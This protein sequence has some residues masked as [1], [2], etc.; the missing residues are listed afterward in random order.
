[1]ELDERA[2]QQL[3]QSGALA[4][5]GEL[6]AGVVHEINNPLFAIL[7]LT[8]FLLKES[9]PGSRAH[10]RLE[11]IQ[12]TG[13]EIKEMVRA[14]LDFARESAD[15]GR[16]EVALADVVRST[17]ELLRRTNA[18][19][20]LELVE[21]YEDGGALI[22]ARPGQLKQLF[23]NL[24]ANAR[25]AMPNGGTVKIRVRTDGGHAVATVAD[26]GPG[27]DPAVAARI[28]EPFFTTRPGRGGMGLAVSRA[29]A[30]SHGGTLTVH[31][32]AGAGSEFCLRLPVCE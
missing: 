17:V 23:L 19:R 21:A 10:D 2:A 26:G 1:V 15:E 24:L 28:F 9:E 25:Q 7:G 3:V 22:L 27:I 13:L 12:Q 18:D 11:L 4:A 20:G 5:I 29:I 14:L 31:Q 8:E 30:E 16:H 6:T 32:G